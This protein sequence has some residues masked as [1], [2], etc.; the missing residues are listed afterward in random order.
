M[1]NQNKNICAQSC[2]HAIRV[3]CGLKFILFFL[4][5]LLRHIPSVHMRLEYALGSYK[6]QTVPTAHSAWKWWLSEMHIAVFQ[7]SSASLR[8]YRTQH[9]HVLKYHLALIN[10]ATLT[11]SRKCIIRIPTVYSK[12][13]L[14]AQNESWSELSLPSERCTIKADWFLA[15]ITLFQT[16]LLK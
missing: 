3:S 11:I 4:E 5:A 12:Y 15:L 13:P 7:Q 8:I 9:L 2:F 10:S 14:N 1:G 6:K 16:D